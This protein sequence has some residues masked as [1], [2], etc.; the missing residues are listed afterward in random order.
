VPFDFDNYQ[1]AEVDKETLVSIILT[2]KRQVQQPE[3]TVAG[4]TVVD[5]SLRDRLVKNSRNSGKPS[6]SVCSHCATAL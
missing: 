3:K 1:L 6:S 5:Q 2:I 4:Q